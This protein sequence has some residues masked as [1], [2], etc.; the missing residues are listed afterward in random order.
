MTDHDNCGSCG[1][2]CG[3]SVCSAGACAGAC[4]APLEACGS[5]CVDLASSNT[6]CGACG[7]AC[8]R[9]QFCDA[10]ACT[11]SKIEHVVLIVEEN[12]TFDTYFGNYCTAEAGSEP[13]CT[14]GPS[15]CEA[16]PLTDPTGASPT[17]LDDFANELDDRDHDR[18]CEV[19]QIDG[20]LMDHYVTGSG[21]SVSELESLY[22]YDCSDPHNFALAD[23][24]TLQTY[25]TYADQGALA[26]RYFQPSVGSTSANDMY[27]AVAQWQFD[28]N[29]DR[30]DT[31]G[32]GCLA[33]DGV[34]TIF[35][36]EATVADM[37]VG[38]GITFRM[39]ADGYADAVKAA[40]Q[41]ASAAGIFPADCESFEMTTVYSTCNYDPSDLPFEY[42]PLFADNPRYIVD[43]TQF[44][45]DVAGGQLP[46]FAYVKPRTYRNEHPKWSTISRGIDQVTAVVN[47]IENSPYASN[48]LILLTWDE[49]GGFYDHVSP[50]ATVA[51]RYDHDANG[52]AVPYGT[53][54]PMLAIGP[55]AAAGTVSHVQME[56]SSVVRFLEYNFLGPKYAGALGRRD[57]VVN[58]LGSLLDPSTTGITIPP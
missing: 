24:S 18:V 30:P 3:G 5:A 48:T 41:C 51:T 10:G 43:S 45:Q 38:S 22:T 32:S 20:G 36:H 1:S 13:T 6:D 35:L 19:A 44:A 12:H 49:G 58:N 39:Y 2:S 4:A 47:A 11:T 33:P 27:L 17:A 50:P 40:P 42:Y 25:W 23:S 15:C 52:A 37:L 29:T 55:F 53:R 7:N 9:G 14:E 57:A 31:I 56:H 16:A 34:A 54:V 28:D 26:D 21:V 8:A 46:Q